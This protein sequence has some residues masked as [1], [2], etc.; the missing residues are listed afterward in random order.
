MGIPISEYLSL[1][2]S[3]EYLVITHRES[4]EIIYYKSVGDFD[5]DIL[6]IFRSSIQ[7]EIFDLPSEIEGIEQATLEGKYLLT[8]AGKLVWVTLILKYKP[9]R[10]TREVLKFFCK[11]F[12]NQ[13]EREII[14]LYTKFE[15]DISVFQQD[16]YSRQSL[17]KEIEDIFHLYLAY[18]FQIGSIRGIKINNKAKKIYKI[19]KALTHK[20]KGQFF[21]NKL[22]FEVSKSSQ[23]NNIELAK[24]IY[25][26][27]EIGVLIPI[28]DNKMKKRFAINF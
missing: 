9:I 13:Y 15:G 23:L 4:R 25:N 5:P 17:N 1:A 24:I 28:K 3:I 12:E 14:D 26:L 16:P 18:P 10:I 20:A 19:A 27:V 6:D 2:L 8:R 22:F 11:L 7:Y 21:L